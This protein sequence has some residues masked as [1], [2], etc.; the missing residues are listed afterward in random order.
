MP[1]KPPIDVYHGRDVR[2]TLSRFPSRTSAAGCSG[3]AER[4]DISQ[5]TSPLP[6]ATSLNSIHRGTHKAMTLSLET[7][8]EMRDRPLLQPVQDFQIGSIYRRQLRDGV[9]GLGGGSVTGRQQR[10]Q[11]SHRQ[12]RLSSAGALSNGSA[13]GR[14][15]MN[16]M[17]SL[18]EQEGFRHTDAFRELSL[19][20]RLQ[21]PPAFAEVYRRRNMI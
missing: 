21:L 18:Y 19:T 11:H 8:E 16:S 4:H 3:W 5:L 15:G 1:S 14:D 9:S 20:G 2:S 12:L 13:A 7:S 17:R 6:M 10:K